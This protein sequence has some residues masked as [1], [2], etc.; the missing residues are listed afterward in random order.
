VLPARQHLHRSD[1]LG[2]DVTA[3]AYNAVL[4]DIAADHPNVSVIDWNS[5]AL[6]HPEYFDNDPTQPHGNTS[7]QGAYRSV[8]TLGAASCAYML[9]QD[10]TPLFFHAPAHPRILRSMNRMSSSLQSWT[11]A[12]TVAVVPPCSARKWP[13]TM[14][15]NVVASRA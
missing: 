3:P 14:S 1:K 4:D 15:R 7:G 10:A 5:L 8:I 12:M 6:V 13:S 2:L 9:E 11:S